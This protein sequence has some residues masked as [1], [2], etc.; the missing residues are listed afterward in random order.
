M[1]QLQHLLLRLLPVQQQMQDRMVLAMMR[2]RHL[3][4]ST[5]SYLAHMTGLMIRHC[6]YTHLAFMLAC[7]P[8]AI[9]NITIAFDVAHTVMMI[10]VIVAVMY[11]SSGPIRHMLMEHCGA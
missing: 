8:I 4:T 3:C 1:A 11:T 10:S 5:G 9:V 2:G 6:C 7:V